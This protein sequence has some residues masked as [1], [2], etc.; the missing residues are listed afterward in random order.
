MF[1]F[2]LHKWWPLARLLWKCKI[3]ALE[4]CD[5]LTKDWS[6]RIQRH[7]SH[8]HAG[9]RAMILRLRGQWNGGFGILICWILICWQFRRN[10]LFYI[11]N[12]TTFTNASFWNK[13]NFHFSFFILYYFLP[14]W[15]IF[16]NWRCKWEASTCGRAINCNMGEQSTFAAGSSKGI[17]WLTVLNARHGRKH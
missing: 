7:N 10:C 12:C 9:K 2:Q 13:T 1:F 3:S 17:V 15:W 16:L 14:L 5:I 8:L 4:R 11:L 6:L